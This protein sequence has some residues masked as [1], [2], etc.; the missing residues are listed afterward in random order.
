MDKLFILLGSYNRLPPELIDF[1]KIKLKT[2]TL[3]RFEVLVKGGEIN[4]YIYFIERGITRTYANT[5]DGE[6][7]TWL[8]QVGE[9]V[10]SINSF[11]RQIPSAEWIIAQT[12]LTVRYIS[13]DELE[14]ACRR[15]PD[16]VVVRERLK[17]EYYERKNQYD[18]WLLTTKRRDRYLQFT[19]EQPFLA[20]SISLQVMASYLHMDYATLK[21]IRREIREGR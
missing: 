7:T 14:E 20:K 1:L 6:V 9:L 15:W 2:K 13:F 11:F 19:K 12:Q 21:R 17:T 10:V 8:Q 18:L 4:R 16:F 5:E 3:R